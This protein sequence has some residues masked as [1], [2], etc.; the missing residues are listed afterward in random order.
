MSNEE[1]SSAAEGLAELVAARERAEGRFGELEDEQ[2]A[3]YAARDE[4]RSAVVAA[5][6]EGID[7]REQTRLE[8]AL[9]AA[10]GRPRSPGL[11]G[12]RA[13]APQSAMP[14]GRCGSTRPST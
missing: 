13:A 3:A 8:K 5:E 1:R 6:R 10:D 11:R 2:R 7:P 12:S 4:A 9:A 14:T